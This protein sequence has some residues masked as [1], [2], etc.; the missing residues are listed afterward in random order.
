MPEKVVSDSDVPAVSAE[1]SQ[2]ILIEGQA[3][4]RVSPLSAMVLPTEIFDAAGR[5]G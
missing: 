3:T 5:L 4:R 2:E 1:P